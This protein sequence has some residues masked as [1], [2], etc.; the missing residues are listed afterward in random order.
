MDG[1]FEL[2]QE[3]QL[4]NP[5]NGL[6]QKPHGVLC[7]TSVLGPLQRL[8]LLDNAMLSMVFLLLG[9]RLALFLQISLALASC[10][11]L[12]KISHRTSSGT[13]PLT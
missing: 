2:L 11:L 4:P 6:I 9:S 13:A 5:V 8:S 10:I 1:P 12:L 3:T 7:L